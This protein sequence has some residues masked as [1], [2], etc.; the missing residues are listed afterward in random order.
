VFDQ[1]KIPFT[2]IHAKDIRAGNL[3]SRFDAII[4]PDQQSRAIANGP[5]GHYPDSLKGGVGAPG[6][7][8][9]GAFVDQGGTLVA[10]NDASNYA[11]EALSLP[12]ENVL[13]GVSS[14]DFYAPGSILRVVLDRSNPLTAGYTAP[15]QAVWF[16]GSPAFTVRDSTRVSVVAR[17]P[18]ASMNPLISGWLLGAPILAKKA[19][20]VDVK[21]GKGHVV[22][23][24]FRPQYRAQS[25]ATYPLLWNA[26]RE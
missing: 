23:F 4:I 21:R 10:F 3:N 19:A 26:L 11:I 2:T 7:E 13:A 1:Y 9:L 6:A 16:E 24:G 25:M 17:Y 18:D 14:S 20:M 12:V 15:E 8:A 5:N 22:L